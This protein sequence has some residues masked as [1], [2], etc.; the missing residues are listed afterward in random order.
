MPLNRKVN[1]NG[2][3]RMVAYTDLLGFSDLVVRDTELAKE[4]LSDFYNLAQR[5]KIRDG[6]HELELFLFSDFLFVQ[7]NEVS[8]VVN[9]AC[10]LYMEALK[11]SETGTRPMLCR[12]GIARGAVISQRRHQAPNVSKNFIISPALAHAV[13]MES[14]VKGQ[15]LLL[16]ANEK[17]ELSHFW[18]NQ[19]HAIC[20]DQPSI[21]PS[22]LFLKYRYQDILWAR[23]LARE[24][25]DAKAET[26]R[27]IQIASRLFQDNHERPKS[28][29]AHYA[30]TL[31]ICM[32]SFAG[33]LEPCAEDRALLGSLVDV[34]T[35]YPDE[36]T[37]LGFMEMV[38][39]SRDAFA[40]QLDQSVAR[41]LRFA[42]LSPK[43]GLV[44]ASLE[45]NENHQ[46]LGAVRELIDVAVHEGE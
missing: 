33:M 26:R 32:L 36:S 40:F 19:I 25:P 17:E 24:Y 29:N 9:Y 45:R 43:W 18:N 5:I 44:C 39:L 6:F 23:D 15:R 3:H 35:S 7:G 38:F 21:K 22:K 37:W 4:L 8:L 12:G 42:L 31:R 41:F 2:D 46:L 10:K 13:K 34:L 30:E 20:Y 27:L 11:Y 1:M 16:A 14:L 28:V